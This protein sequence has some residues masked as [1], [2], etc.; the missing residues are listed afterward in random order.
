MA[1]AAVRIRV[2][3]RISICADKARAAVG[4]TRNGCALM[5]A[6]PLGLLTRGTNAKLK[7]GDILI[8]Y[9]AADTFQ[10]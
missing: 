6:G 5:R 8:G 7:A 1:S 4:A 3:K 10:Q 2:S 9:V